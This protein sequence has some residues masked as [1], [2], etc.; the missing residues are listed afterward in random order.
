MRYF[1]RWKRRFHIVFFWWRSNC[2]IVTYQLVKRTHDVTLII[3]NSE[4]LLRLLGHSYLKH[5]KSPPSL[6]S[7]QANSISD[8]ILHFFFDNWTDKAKST[9]Q[10]STDKIKNNKHST[11]NYWKN[12]IQSHPGQTQTHQPIFHSAI[13]QHLIALL[14]PHP[15]NK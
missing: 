6:F 11:L 14:H 13:L 4:K 2:K 9:R 12:K 8:I 10:P 5:L 7:F 3:E 1:R 15:P